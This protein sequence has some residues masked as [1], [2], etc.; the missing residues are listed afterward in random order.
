MTTPQS[1]SIHEP[2]K[3]AHSVTNVFSNDGSFLERF[4]KNS[5]SASSLNAQAFEALARRKEYELVLKY[6]RKP[7]MLLDAGVTRFRSVDI[8]E[9]LASSALLNS[10]ESGSSIS[11]NSSYSRQLNEYVSQLTADDVDRNRPLVK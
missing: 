2:G 1:S 3:K 8:K 6:R 5:S 10:S 9:R 11:G 7:Q 4:Q